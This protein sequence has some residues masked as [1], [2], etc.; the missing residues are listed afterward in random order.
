MLVTKILYIKRTASRN[1]IIVDAA[2]NDFIRPSFYD[3]YHE[4]IPEKEAIPAT[5]TLVA[6]IV[7]PVCETGDIFAEQR[8]IPEA[9]VGNLLIFRSTGAYGAVM[10]STYNSRLL[11]P[12]VLVKGDQFAVIRPRPTY[13][14]MLRQEIMPDWLKS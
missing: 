10:A 1:F 9:E 12:E 3:A 2:M 5:P 6:D 8:I 7:G 11:V 14:D 13:E 4:I